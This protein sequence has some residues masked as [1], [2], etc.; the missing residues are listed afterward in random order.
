[1]RM[2]AGIAAL[3]V[4]VSALPALAVDV[5]VYESGSP[6]SF[7]T[8]FDSSTSSVVRFGDSGWLSGSGS[9]API[10]ISKM[11]LRVAAFKIGRAHV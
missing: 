3:A 1:M 4:G 7:F 2:F 9:A 10:V 6:T 11:V 8:P 5:L